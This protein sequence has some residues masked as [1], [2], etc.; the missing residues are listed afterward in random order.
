MPAYAV[1]Y[2]KEYITI[3]LSLKFYLS[4]PTWC[5]KSWN[6]SPMAKFLPTEECSQQS[7]SGPLCPESTWAASF[8]W[9]KAQL[10]KVG[11]FP[12]LDFPYHKSIALS[13]SS[14]L[15][16]CW[17]RGPGEAV[18]PRNCSAALCLRGKFKNW[19]IAAVKCSHPAQNHQNLL[20][21]FE[22]DSAG[23]TISLCRGVKVL[24]PLR[25]ANSMPSVQGR[26]QMK[27]PVFWACLESSKTSCDFFLN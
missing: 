25:R 3:F 7:W 15:P 6:A 8:V 5:D 19:N 10:E 24:T 23:M 4:P 9:V 26:H 1:K 20:Q 22:A 27:T 13:R 16:H 14:C 12:K 11:T 2:R 18:C 17:I 21:Y